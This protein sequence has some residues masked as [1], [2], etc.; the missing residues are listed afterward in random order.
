[1]MAT[2]DQLRQTT[3]DALAGGE[4]YQPAVYY[5]TLGQPTGGPTIRV[6]ASN[7]P[8][9]PASPM[10]AAPDLRPA[11]DANGA[12]AD[13]RYAAG[14]GQSLINNK[15]SGRSIACCSGQHGYAAAG[16]V[17]FGQ[18]CRSPT[19]H[20][21]RRVCP[22]GA[23]PTC[24]RAWG[25]RRRRLCRLGTLRHCVPS[26]KQLR[27]RSEAAGDGGEGGAQSIIAEARRF[28]GGHPL[29][30]QPAFGPSW[31]CRRRCAVPC[32]R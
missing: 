30:D 16:A 32:K 21:R 8:A 1:M 23:A 28:S 10:P 27:R 13:A 17:G 12:T 26:C 15:C 19:E 11:V 22:N 4:V 9:Q 29:E 6:G 5:D 7:A 3:L 24:S 14:I 20:Q 2:P 25:Y 18:A 31:C